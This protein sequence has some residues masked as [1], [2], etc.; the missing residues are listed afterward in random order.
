MNMKQI[1]M[2]SALTLSFIV[3]ELFSKT[4][5]NIL[6][7][8]LY[9][10]LIFFAFF[11]LDTGEIEDYFQ[12]YSEMCVY[13]DDA[14]AHFE[15]IDLDPLNIEVFKMFAGGRADSQRVNSKDGY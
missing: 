2:A 7:Y 14:G 11:A 13:E 5:R 12:K 8:V 4:K 10:A 9:F 1:L 15:S 3:I 6:W